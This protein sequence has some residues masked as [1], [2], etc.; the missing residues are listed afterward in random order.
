M[1]LAVLTY[2]IS[3]T[4]PREEMFGMTSQARRA[5][6]SV[7]ANIAEGYGRGTRPAYISFLRI[8]QGSLKELETHMML[9]VRVGIADAASVER[10][11]S[12]ADRLG[13]MIRTLLRKLAS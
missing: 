10:L 8:S 9:A 13:R 3:R 4:F 2:D 1:D 7:A 5:A 12:E 6:A 11:L